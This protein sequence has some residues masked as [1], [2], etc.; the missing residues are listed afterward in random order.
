M[1]TAPPSLD[2]TPTVSP[3]AGARRRPVFALSLLCLAALYVGLSLS[4]SSF[5][6]F[7]SPDSGARF[8][9]IRSWQ[10]HGRFV[11]LY[12][13][14]AGADPSGRLHPLAYFL[15]RSPH[16][17]STMYQPLFPLLCGLA[18]R[19][20][21]F[22][23]LSL[24]PVLCG[25][26][27]VIATRATAR[28]I[29]LFPLWLPLVMGFATPLVL[30]SVIFWDHSALMLLAAWAGY[31]MLRAVQDGDL[32]PALVTGAL[33]GVGLWVHELCLALFL[34][35]CLAALPLLRLRRH[36]IGGLL[37]GFAPVSALWGFCNWILYGAVGGAH[38]GANVFQNSQNHPFSLALILDPA[39]LA[40]RTML[41]L[42]GAAFS[43]YHDT[44]LPYIRIFAVTLASF[45]VVSWL[46]RRLR[47][48]MPI[49]SLAIALMALA[50]TLSADWVSG[51]FEGTPLL[52]PA[53]AV[54]WS[55]GREAANTPAPP[56]AIFFAWLS[57]TCWLFALFVLVDPITPGVDWGGRYLLPMLPLLVLLSAHALQRSLQDAPG[58]KRTAAAAL[59]IL[60]GI[61]AACQVRGLQT[62]RLTM[63][64][65]QALSTQVGRLNT[66]VLVTDSLWTGPNLM[67]APL[68][69]PLLLIRSG[70]DVSLLLSE[71]HR[72]NAHEFTYV[73]TPE[74]LIFFSGLEKRLRVTAEH[75]PL[76]KQDARSEAEELEV[77]AYSV[78]P[79]GQVE[80]ADDVA[81]RP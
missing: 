2:G 65:N 37:L 51:L 8:A 5:H 45:T 69:E 76:H 77:T 7:W 15:F 55:V 46:S 73:G 50:L 27:T 22:A 34:A 12:Y 54:P 40:N 68:R 42:F 44:L 63:A 57:R 79:T 14:P 49:L 25:L 78:E 3:T 71:M 13:P 67:A 48:V 31:W 29:G 81:G 62:V 52:I 53:L 47:P 9:M 64:D 4:L 56:T 60:V 26:G 1:I 33:L 38:L 74:G 11:P 24:L 19:A 43:D 21:G 36:I 39:G 72:M 17:L 18:Y 61:S 30:Y 80:G 59:V 58:G 6:A 23:G 32:R 20:F 28:R 75:P 70:A 35:T 66:P 10:E 41:E 16:G